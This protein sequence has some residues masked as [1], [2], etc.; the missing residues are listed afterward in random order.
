[1]IVNGVMAKVSNIKNHLLTRKVAVE[2]EDGTVLLNGVLASG[3]CDDNPDTVERIVNYE[4]KEA[5][6]ILITIIFD[7]YIIRYQSMISNHCKQN[8]IVE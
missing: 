7:A 5:H 2:T 3:I 6:C 4:R 1:M 8:C